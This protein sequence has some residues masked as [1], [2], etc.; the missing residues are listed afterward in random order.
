MKLTRSRVVA[1]AFVALLLTV[2]IA[3]SVRAAETRDYGMSGGR[4]IHFFSNYLDL[5]DAQQEQVKQIVAKDQP[6]VQPLV[7]QMHQSRQQ[8][9]QVIEGGAFDEAKVRALASQQTQTITELTVQRA[10]LYS[11]LYQVLTSDQKSKLDK[12]LD[13]HEQ[14]FRKPTNAAPENQ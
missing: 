8:L 12:F 3:R 2:T 9:R 4:M 11:D 7:Q 6:S 1:G 10:H 14:R 5:T 13:R